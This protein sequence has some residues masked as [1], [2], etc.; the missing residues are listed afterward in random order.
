MRAAGSYY[1]TLNVINKK[2]SEMKPNDIKILNEIR[3]ELNETI[4]LKKVR[5]SKVKEAKK[6]FNKLQNFVIR[7]YVNKPHNINEDEE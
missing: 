4:R 6:F 7:D 1:L 3:N 2:H 5:K